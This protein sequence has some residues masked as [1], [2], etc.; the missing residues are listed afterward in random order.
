MIK[1]IRQRWSRLPFWVNRFALGDVQRGDVPGW[2]LVTVMS[3]GLVV[4]IFAAF[5][6]KIVNA[7]TQAI[8]NVVS[9]S[10]G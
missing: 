1:R 7:V 4:A 10:G 5:K 9:G 2:V 6:G 8:D 3:A